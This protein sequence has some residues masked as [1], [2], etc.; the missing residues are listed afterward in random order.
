MTLPSAFAPALA[1]VQEFWQPLPD[2]PEETPE[3]VAC[4][5]WLAAAG[6]PVSAVE[7]LR[8]DLPELGP[9]GEERLRD[10][11][12]RKRSG[13]PLAHLTG[14]QSFMG[15]E[16]M[17]GP[18]ALIPRK[19]TEILAGAVLAKLE[20]L[21]R[22]RTS[23]LV[24]DLCTGS[25]NLAVAYAAHEPSARVFAADLSAAAVALAEHNRRLLDLPAERIQFRTGDLFAPFENEEFLGRCDLVSCNPPYISAAKVPEMHREISAF[26]PA[27]A[28]DGGIYGVSI[29]TRLIKNAPRF[30]KPASWLCFE[31]GLGQGELMARQLQ[32]IPAYS[33]VETAADAAGEI[34][35]LLARTA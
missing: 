33:T 28:F 20:M 12:A 30:L 17:A 32:R 11:L 1:A 27:M 21:A 4:A 8:L 15:L 6:T 9:E 23:L 26:E 10:L 16:L 19:E 2:K 5:L 22:E 24:L 34:R 25:G 29:L 18:E 31:V 35:A 7:A 3:A 14:R 13:T